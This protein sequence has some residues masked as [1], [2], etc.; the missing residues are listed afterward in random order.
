MICDLGDNLRPVIRVQL[1]AGAVQYHQPRIRSGACDSRGVG[2]I[3]D[4]VLI[5]VDY[6]YRRPDFIGAPVRG[7]E[8][9]RPA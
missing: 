6:Q 9:S 4:G 5:S 8:P 1:M 2:G 7:E 3:N